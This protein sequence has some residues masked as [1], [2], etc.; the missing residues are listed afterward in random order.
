MTGF[1]YFLL[2]TTLFL[3]KFHK[4]ISELIQMQQNLSWED[5][6]KVDIRVGTIVYAEVF[7]E[8]KNAAYKIQIDFGEEIGIRKTSAQVTKLYSPED[9]IGKQVMAVVNFPPKQIANIMSECLLLGAVGE[10]G[11]VTLVQTER[12]T[13]NGLRIG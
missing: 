5:F 6:K 9:L 3:S 7:K 4:T 1:F 10:N 8:V 2:F 11:E 12:K 13:V